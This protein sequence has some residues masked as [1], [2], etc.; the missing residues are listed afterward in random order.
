VVHPDHWA[1]RRR[2]RAPD[3]DPRR[4]QGLPVGGGFEADQP[5][6]FNGSIPRDH[7]ILDGETDEGTGPGDGEGFQILGETFDFQL[8]GTSDEAPNPA[9]PAPGDVA[10]GRLAGV[11]AGGDSGEGSERFVV[12]RGD[13]ANRFPTGGHAAPGE[14]I[15]PHGEHLGVGGQERR[16]RGGVRRSRFLLQRDPVESMNPALPGREVDLGGGSERHH[17]P[18]IIVLVLAEREI[19]NPIVVALV[20][21]QK[22]EGFGRVQ[23]ALGGSRQ[24]YGAADLIRRAR[25][26]RPAAAVP[27]GDAS[28]KIAEILPG[29]DDI[30]EAGRQDGL[31]FGRALH[32]VGQGREPMEGSVFEIEQRWFGGEI[33]RET[34]S[35]DAVRTAGGG[36]SQAQAKVAGTAGSQG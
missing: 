21:V 32:A 25:K 28:L 34:V 2:R 12:T 26:Q 16:N 14:S 4:G 33:E 30:I 1:G 13:P 31:D 20:P 3:R 8:G 18:G 9:Q 22:A 29:D 10:W 6:R 23:A 27:V 35:D 5:R 19:L 36:S 7:E 15:L 11:D 17:G 24:G